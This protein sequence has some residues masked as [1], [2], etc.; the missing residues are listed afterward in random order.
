MSTL[1]LMLLRRSIS[2]GTSFGAARACISRSSDFI[3]LRDSNLMHRMAFRDGVPFEHVRDVLYDMPSVDPDAI[4]DTWQYASQLAYRLSMKVEDGLGECSVQDLCEMWS[5]HDTPS[6]LVNRALCY[7]G[8]RESE[9]EYILINVSKTL[10]LQ[11]RRG[12][13]ARLEYNAASGVELDWASISRNYQR[14]QA[15]ESNLISGKE[16]D[17]LK[18]GNIKT[19]LSQRRCNKSQVYHGKR[20]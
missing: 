18:F 16:F 20:K 9:A 5:V 19:I 13:W 7:Q 1:C 12:L 15:H 4:D 2:K 14:L 17:C 3:V 11:G 8:T 10:Q 6:L